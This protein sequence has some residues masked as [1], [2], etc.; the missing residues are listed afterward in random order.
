[1]RTHVYLLYLFLPSSSLEL[2]PQ[3]KTYQKN[4]TKLTFSWMDKGKPR[5]KLYR[6]FYHDPHISPPPSDRDWVTIPWQARLKEIVILHLPTTQTKA[7][8]GR[9]VDGHSKD[10]NGILGIRR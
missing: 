9:R 8:P 6:R 10:L 2:Y 3:M 5:Q 1:M 4:S 7:N